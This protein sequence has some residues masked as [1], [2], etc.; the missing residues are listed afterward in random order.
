MSAQRL[1]DLFPFRSFCPVSNL[2]F[3]C[4]AWH[5]CLKILF[6]KNR[7]YESVKVFLFFFD[8]LK[9]FNTCKKHDFF[10]KNL[11]FKKGNT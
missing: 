11:N 4:L 3:E 5:V 7:Y 8:D 9:K 6:D 1:S 2:N 10:P